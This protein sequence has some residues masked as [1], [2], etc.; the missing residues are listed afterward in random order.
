MD[1]LKTA[2]TVIFS[3]GK[4]WSRHLDFNDHLWA[5]YHFTPLFLSS[6]SLWLFFP[7]SSHLFTPLRRFE[8]SV[9]RAA[10]CLP[11]PP[12]SPANVTG[13]DVR[14]AFIFFIIF[15]FLLLLETAS[16]SQDSIISFKQ[17]KVRQWQLWTSREREAASL[18]SANHSANT[19][20]VVTCLWKIVARKLPVWGMKEESDSCQLLT[21]IWERSV[22]V[23]GQLLLQTL[24]L[25]LIN[26]T[27]SFSSTLL[28]ESSWKGN[29]KKNT[30]WNR[31]AALQ[32]KNPGR[33]GSLQ[34]SSSGSRTLEQSG[35]SRH[36]PISCM[37]R[38][39]DPSCPWNKDTQGRDLTR[40]TAV[41]PNNPNERNTSNLFQEHL[42]CPKLTWPH[43]GWP[44][45]AVGT[46]QYGLQLF[47]SELY[48][49]AGV[50]MWRGAK[51]QEHDECCQPVRASTWRQHASNTTLQKEYQIEVNLNI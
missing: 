4:I 46:V 1:D 16:Q 51:L 23:W 9:H 48:L 8:P 39:A 17:N 32:D 36:G 45:T 5:N 37:L 35:L 27:E 15:F 30:S 6:L 7:F 29:G 33:G 34:S 42:T 20:E 10:L 26:G 11:P 40:N 47:S 31:S 25:C 19:F 13:N 44:L 2:H 22:G 43:P 12:L 49:I 41:R 38:T 21:S 28:T 18:S 3:V 50:K 24:L 14:L